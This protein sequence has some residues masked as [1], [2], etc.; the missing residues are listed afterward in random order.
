MRVVHLKRH[1]L[2]Q[3]MDIVM[4]F[5]EL[6]ERALYTGRDEEILLTQTQLLALYVVIV[7]IE[8]VN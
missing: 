3:V 7:R 1:L 5:H 8:H 4:V 6:R 2:R